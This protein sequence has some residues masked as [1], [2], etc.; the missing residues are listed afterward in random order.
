M[1]TLFV[2]PFFSGRFFL[3]VSAPLRE[4]YL[5]TVFAWHFFR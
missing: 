2:T 1:Q 3:C 4:N 5:P